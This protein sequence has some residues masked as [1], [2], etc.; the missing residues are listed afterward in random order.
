MPGKRLNSHLRNTAFWKL[1]IACNVLTLFALIALFR[2]VLDTGNQADQK[3][4]EKKAAEKVQQLDQVITSRMLQDRVNELSALE[5]I[6]TNN[7]TE[8]QSR[9]NNWIEGKP[10]YVSVSIWVG[11]QK[12]AVRSIRNAFWNILKKNK[13]TS[14]SQR[15]IYQYLLK[16]KPPAS[17]ENKKW[18]VQ[19]IFKFPDT[20]QFILTLVVIM[21]PTSS[22]RILSSD[23]YFSSIGKLFDFT[24][25][26]NE[27][28]GLLEPTGEVIFA[29][30]GFNPE[31]IHFINK[32]QYMWFKDKFF[33]LHPMGELP[34][35]MVLQTSVQI[36]AARF[37]ISKR[38]EISIYFFGF[39]F[40]SLISLLLSRWIVAPLRKLV[41]HV[42]EIGRGDFSRK[43]PRQKDASLDR[44]ALL[45]NYMAKEMSQ[46]QKLNVSEIIG[47]KI[48]TETIIRDIADGVLVTD[49]QDRIIM[50][51][52]VAEDWF[53][54]HEKSNYQKP[55]QKILKNRSLIALIQ[56]VK[57]G[58]QKQSS[59]I[60]CRIYGSNQLKMFQANAARV[61]NEDNK[62]LGIVTV[63][64]DVTKER[65]IDQL[66]TDLVSMVAHE[67][68][69]PLTSIY[70]F[71][72][73][74]ME[75]NLDDHQA[76]EYAKVIQMESSRLTE[77]V[78]KFLD[79]SRLEQ[80]RVEINWMP[81]DIQKLI[82]RVV[83]AHQQL[84]DKKD[85]RLIK[86]FPRVLCM[87][88][89][90]SDLI[91]QV[92]INLL[93]NAIKYS[94]T[95]SKIG[96]EVNEKEN[97]I[98]ISII[99]NGYGIPKDSLSKIFNK[100]YRVVDPDSPEEIEGS[101]LGLAL[102]RE[103]VER[104]GSEINV[105]SKQ[106][107]GSVFRFSLKKVNMNQSG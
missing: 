15:E 53:G 57:D 74:L 88:N 18:Y 35:T 102:V 81:F 101:G 34:W 39:V 98:E 45:F 4:A 66:K 91:E 30:Q 14:V 79:L 22:I 38:E 71:S 28:I 84:A 25:G 42:I 68:K 27:E 58:Q 50:M 37:N 41:S 100:F 59:D 90:D 65:E 86:K 20:D 9:L 85:I 69:A 24:L 103:I 5:T 13:R 60:R 11:N 6:F 56:D 105:K 3:Q 89:G 36:R 92:I 51:N 80:G 55:I 23:L 43:I 44:I 8:M 94:P 99:D 97:D 16:Q 26:Q 96:I 83:I 12:W 46:L 2:L 61:H 64:R 40:A 107:V 76:S 70:G 104:H 49:P 1:F 87:V 21:P 32:K 29:S 75:A 106:G 52:A 33:F 48:K 72:E 73:L 17:P 7:T 67:L 82:D 95:G 54:L 31:K 10:D 47:E 63:L 77:L 62:L 19:S 78:N 93:S